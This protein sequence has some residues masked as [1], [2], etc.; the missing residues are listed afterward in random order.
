M[1]HVVHLPLLIRTLLPLLKF[2]PWDM[3]RLGQIISKVFPNIL[4][5][6]SL[7][8]PSLASTM[9]HV[10]NKGVWVDLVLISTIMCLHE[11]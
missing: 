6:P 7:I 4:R 11:E 8:I 10:Y 9:I 3:I 1:N 2:L 5:I